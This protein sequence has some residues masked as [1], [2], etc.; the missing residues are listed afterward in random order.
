MKSSKFEEKHFMDT[1][2]QNLT[3][4]VVLTFRFMQLTNKIYSYETFGTTE[5]D[6]MLI[7]GWAIH[8]SQHLRAGL[9]PILQLIYIQTFRH[10]KQVCN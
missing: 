7:F 6:Q 9:C 10:Q 2:K 3:E 1:Q 4:F 5:L 8:E